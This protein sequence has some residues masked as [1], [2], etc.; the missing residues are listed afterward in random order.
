MMLL[1]AHIRLVLLLSLIMLLLELL[2]LQKQVFITIL[3]END[4]RRLLHAII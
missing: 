4:F 1:S 2:L 3:C